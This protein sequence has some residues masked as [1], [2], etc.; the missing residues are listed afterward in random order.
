[1]VEGST[2][3]FGI[4]EEDDGEE[5]GDFVRGESDYDDFRDGKRK[6][7]EKDELQKSE[8]E[9]GIPS[10]MRDAWANR[11]NSPLIA[12]PA[13][14]QKI[15]NSRRCTQENKKRPQLTKLPVSLQL[16]LVQ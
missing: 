2:P 10:T 13:E 6:K 5:L 4:G 15:L 11:R 14:D 1:M 16:P 12:S 8:T 7:F 9:I 3:D